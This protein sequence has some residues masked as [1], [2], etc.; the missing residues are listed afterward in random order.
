MSPVVID[1][2]VIENRP[3]T[4][5]RQFLDR[6]EASGDQEAYRFPVGDHWESI[7]WKETGAKVSRLAAGLVALG[8]ANFAGASWYP[9]DEQVFLWMAI[10][11]MYGLRV[12]GP[13]AQ[14]AR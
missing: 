14:G 10:G 2:S 12:R 11:M 5:S 3:M 8:V 1:Q 9:S 4:V 7:T 13:A 6:V